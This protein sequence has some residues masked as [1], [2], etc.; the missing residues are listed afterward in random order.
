[1]TTAPEH[2]HPPAAPAHRDDDNLLSV[3]ILFVFYLLCIGVAAYLYWHGT[4]KPPW[5]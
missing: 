2:H 5:A 1:M 3:A 4:G